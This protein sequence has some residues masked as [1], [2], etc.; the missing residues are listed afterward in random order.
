[1]VL[2]LIP[3]FLWFYVFLLLEIRIC[4]LVN[5]NLSKKS[6]YLNVHDIFNMNKDNRIFYLLN[7]YTNIICIV[8]Y[9]VSFIYNK[10]YIDST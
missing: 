7:N 1:M 5:G 2:L 9:D 4:I 6:K 10:L 8:M 3:V